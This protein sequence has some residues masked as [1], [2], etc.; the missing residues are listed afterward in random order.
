M[1]RGCRTSSA[2][3]DFPTWNATWHFGSSS[4]SF[5]GWPTGMLYQQDSVPALSIACRPLVQISAAEE[6]FGART[7][8]DRWRQS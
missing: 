4:I 8:K 3:A 5:E 1:V 2:S 7:D 6:N